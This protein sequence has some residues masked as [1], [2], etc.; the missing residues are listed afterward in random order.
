M[1][2]KDKRVIRGNNSHTLRTQK[3]L[4]DA[5]VITFLLIV[6]DILLL[7]IWNIILNFIFNIPINIETNTIIRYGFY[8]GHSAWKFYIIYI[9]FIGIFDAVQAYRMYTSFSEKD[10][11]VGQKGTQRWTTT[12]EIIEQYKEIPDRD[13]EYDGAPGII[14]SRIG[15]KLYIDPSPVNNLIFG[16]TRSGKDEIY[17]IPSID[18]YSRSKQKPSLIIADPKIETYRIAKKPL[19]KRGYITYL[20]NLDD[21]L[22]SM[23]DNPLDSAI[24]YAKKK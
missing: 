24:Q 3:L 22:H 7:L 9:I 4:S 2:N 23:G 16:I 21:P 14:I 6:E 19:E 18:V 13:E 20:L 1:D 15:R 5:R 10:I 11:N 12:E 8:T 17:V